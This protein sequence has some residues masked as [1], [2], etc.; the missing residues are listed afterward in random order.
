MPFDKDKLKKKDE[1]RLEEMQR[2][3]DEH[4]KS[5][6]EIE[7]N[8]ADAVV[9]DAP[10]EKDEL[11][12]L[13]EKVAED[14]E[15]YKRLQADFE[16]FRRRTRQ[17]KEELSSLVVQNFITEL[18]PMV[19]NFE[20]ALSAEAKDVASFQQ[21]VEMIFGQMMDV[22]KNRGLEPIV[23]HDAKFDPNF[24]QAVM[25]VENPELEDDTIA[26]ELQKGYMVKGKVIR[27]AM[28]QVVS[29]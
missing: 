29:N 1:E 27:P 11:E 16:N 18:L 19:D 24:H 26:A 25:R 6:D 17:E 8:P 28:V 10:E 7:D 13:K 15:R 23:T 14:E 2:E 21:G 4:E 3:I 5:S 12:V 20:R 9:E 22:L